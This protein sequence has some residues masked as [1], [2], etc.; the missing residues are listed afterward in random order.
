MHIR[1]YIQKEIVTVVDVDVMNKICS[2]KFC[3]DDR[4]MIRVSRLYKWL[5]MQLYT[6][7]HGYIIHKSIAIAIH[8]AT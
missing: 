2:G 6:Y 7:M 3:N 4:K 5:Y 1:I 8:I